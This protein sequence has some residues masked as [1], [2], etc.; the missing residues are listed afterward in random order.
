MA[1]PMAPN[2]LWL[3]AT[4]SPFSETPRHTRYAPGGI[5]VGPLGQLLIERR[6]DA[7]PMFLALRLG[8]EARKAL[9]RQLLESCPR[10]REAQA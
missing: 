9:A 8:V 6:M 4:V 5:R 2:N 7:T 1:A 10:G 3:Q